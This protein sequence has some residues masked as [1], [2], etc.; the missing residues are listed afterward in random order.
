MYF[1]IT[2]ALNRSLRVLKAGVLLC[3]FST[4]GKYFHIGT[5]FTAM[6]ENSAAAISLTAGRL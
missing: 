5:I 1:L 4:W 2:Y 6:S 3:S